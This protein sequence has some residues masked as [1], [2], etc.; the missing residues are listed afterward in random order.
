MVLEQG[1][2]ELSV[3]HEHDTSWQVHAG[4]YE[5]IGETYQALGAWV[6]RHAGARVLGFSLVTNK[7]TPDME[8]EGHTEIDGKTFAWGKNDFF[9]VPSYSWRKHV[10]TGKGD[11]AAS[12]M[13]GDVEVRKLDLQDLASVRAFADGVDAVDVLINNAGLE[14]RGSIL[15]CTE[16]DWVRTYDINLKV[17]RHLQ[18]TITGWPGGKPSH[19]KRPGDRSRQRDELLT[20]SLS[21]SL[22]DG[23]A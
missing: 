1:T 4:P 15:Q 19:A 22:P 7:A 6:A 21:L 17:F 13:T 18:S 23:A 11:A 12:G 10:N 5:T 16:E 20:A 9:V 8:G 3:H 2:V 14:I